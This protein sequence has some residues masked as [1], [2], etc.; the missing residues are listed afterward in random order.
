LSALPAKREGTVFSWKEF[1]F[2]K[3]PVD[4]RVVIKLMI[5]VVVY[6][7]NLRAES[8]QRKEIPVNRR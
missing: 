4:L 5:V 2:E 1:E 8:Y 7:S 6:F 3:N